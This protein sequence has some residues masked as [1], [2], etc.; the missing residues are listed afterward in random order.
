MKKTILVLGAAMFVGALFGPGAAKA[1]D[2]LAAPAIDGGVFNTVAL[3]ADGTVWT[4]GTNK[5]GES[6]N[7]FLN[8]I[9][10]NPV[11]LNAGITNAV[12]VASGGWDSPYAAH[13]LVL[14][15]DG[16]VE[17][18]GNNACGQLGDNSGQNQT[19]YVLVSNLTN[20]VAVAAGGYHSLAMKA[21]GTVWAWGTNNFGQIG[22][23]ATNAIYKTPTQVTNLAGVVS[24]AAGMNHSLALKADGTVW[25]WG[26]NGGGQIGN[27]TT[28]NTNLPVAVNTLS[29]VI[30]IAAGGSN[31]LALKADGTVWAWGNNFHGQ[32]GIGTTNA[33]Q[34]VPVQVTNLASVVA[35][36]AGGWHSLALKTDGTVWAW[37]RNN[38]GQA[39]NGTTNVNQTVPVLATN[40]GGVLSL[41]AGEYHSLA[42]LRDGTLAA[43]GRNNFGQVGNGAPI[44]NTNP[45]PVPVNGLAG[46][47]LAVNNH[48]VLGK[49][50]GTVWSFGYNIF[51]Q[52]GDG[53][54]ANRFFPF[55]IGGLQN[56]IATAVGGAHSV[57]LGSN[58]LVQ[59]WGWNG[60]GQVGDGTTTNRNVPASV[61]SATGIMAV[62]AGGQHTL[63]LRTN[64]TLLAWGANGYGQMGNGGVGMASN[65]VPVSGL[66]GGSAS[67]SCL[68]AVHKGRYAI[69]SAI[70]SPTSEV[71]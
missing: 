27:G 1:A 70:R 38:Y 68:L 32:A 54:T 2:G 48:T 16:L 17:A 55:Q 4:W 50:N 8:T 43:W 39:G 63:A 14:R 20:A 56:I 49:T 41:A 3:K 52:V 37:G 64:G 28:V 18:V 57:A 65:A 23:G 10:T 45:I 42:L 13:T 60:C 19:N 21:D 25:A 30:A 58:G 44:G 36:A 66:T 47:G 15:N 34:S 12:A 11:V 51:G 69:L 67:G 22:N 7:G 61:G 5:F 24:V 35:I 59:A 46:V 62:A 29:N 71:E 26:A 53:T 31:S 33:A 9:S 40:L 6:G